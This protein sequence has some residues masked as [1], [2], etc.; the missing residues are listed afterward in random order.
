M[1]I[2]NIPIDAIITKERMR[3]LRPELVDELAASIKAIGIINPI[4]VTMVGTGNGINSSKYILVT[5]LHRLEA[6]KALGYVMIPAAVKEMAQ[7]ERKMAEIDENLVRAD[8]NALEKAIHLA[9]RKRWYN[10]MHSASV[11]GRPTLS[12]L[13]TNRA[14]SFVN[15]T[16]AKT[17]MDGK[18]IHRSVRRAN[19]IPLG[20]QEKIREI[21]RICNNGAALDCLASMPEH[22][23]YAAVAAVQIG[24][25]DRIQDY[26]IKK[27]EE[28][29]NPNAAAASLAF[30][31][32]SRLR[33]ATCE[34]EKL[35]GVINAGQESQILKL[36]EKLLSAIEKRDIAKA[37]VQAQ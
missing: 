36:M 21:P 17:G 20:I 35:L 31:A 3:R 23:Q 2:H 8:L 15:D 12:Q 10:A 27:A 18:T 16:S 32:I 9:E 25:C 11:G 13:G 26:A 6:F 4:T 19:N 1:T 30:R 24:A 29:K 28:V 22:E 37:E 33:S 7:T 34:V 5:G 14:P